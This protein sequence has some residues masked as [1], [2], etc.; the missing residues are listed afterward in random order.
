MAESD[1]L[2]KL[3]NLVGPVKWTWHGSATWSLKP[4]PGHNWRWGISSNVFGRADSGFQAIA[5]HEAEALIQR[6]AIEWLNTD[7]RSAK[8]YGPNCNHVD[9]ERATCE[10]EWC[11]V[12]FMPFALVYGP[13]LLEALLKAVE[14]VTKEKA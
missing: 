3:L 7:G 9:G 8:I 12:V 5:P 4:E 1:T 13:T 6:A 14:A 11:V 2:Q 10:D